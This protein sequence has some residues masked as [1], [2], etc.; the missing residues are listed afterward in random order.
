M[1]NIS[2]IEITQ[3]LAAISN[4]VTHPNAPTKDTL[5]KAPKPKLLDEVRARIRRLNY[6]IRTEECTCHRLFVRFRSIALHRPEVIELL[7][8]RGLIPVLK[9][10]AAR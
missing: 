4:V 3:G 2:W 8:R 10:E 9:G 7:E 1:P 5:S 6:S